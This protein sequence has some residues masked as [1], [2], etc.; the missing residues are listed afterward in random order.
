MDDGLSTVEVA[1]EGVTA[2]ET[3]RTR[4]RRPNSPEKIKIGKYQGGG[5]G[6]WRTGKRIWCLRVEDLRRI[7][8]KRI[9]TE[10]LAIGS[11]I[12]T[13]MATPHKSPSVSSYFLVFF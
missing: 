10:A 7:V 5:V 11:G 6:D 12:L 8:S 4:D 13:K 9:R 2:K 1:E 3:Q